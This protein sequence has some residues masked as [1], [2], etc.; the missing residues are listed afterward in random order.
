M[1]GNQVVIPE[2][3]TGAVANA[4]SLLLA[5]L[6]V[7]KQGFAV[8][9]RN[10]KL[11][12]CNPQFSVVRGYPAELC[13]PGVHIR[14]LF[15]FLAEQ[16]DFATKGMTTAELDAV[17]EDRVQQMSALT[18][19][20]IE[21]ELADGRH[22]IFRYDPIP[23][24]GMLATLVDITDMRQAEEQIQRMARLPEENPTPVMRFNNLAELE[25]SNPASQILRQALGC[26]PGEK[27]PEPLGQLIDRVVESGERIET[28]LDAGGLRYKVLLT[29]IDGA[30]VNLF[31]RDITEVVKARAQL[32]SLAKLPE[33]NPSPVLRFERDGTLLYH[34]SASQQFVD[35]L[36]LKVGEQLSS[37]WRKRFES[38]FKTGDKLEVEY[39]TGKRFYSLIVWP[40]LETNMVNVYGRDITTSKLVQQELIKSKEEA[41]QANQAKSSFL[42]NMSHE[43]RTPLNAIIGYSELLQEEAEDLPGITDLFAP[44]LLKISNAGKHLLGLINEVLDLSKIEA[45]RMDIFVEKFAIQDLITEIEH[46]ISPLIEKNNN[47]LIIQL[48]DEPGYMN[49]DITKIKQTLF[50]LLSNAGK[51]TSDGDITLSMQKLEMSN[52]EYIRFD[53]TD[54]GI[55]MTEEQLDKVFEPFSQADESTTR[56][57][58]G[59]GLGLTICRRFCQILGG[60]ISA[61]SEA[62]KGSVFSAE[63]IADME[64]KPQEALPSTTSVVTDQSATRVLIIDDDSQARELLCRHLSKDGYQIIQSASGS[65]ALA[66]ARE[67]M[68]DV[69][70]LDILMPEVDGWTVLSQLKADPELSNIPVVIVSMIEDRQRGFSLGAADYLTKPIA[71]NELLRVIKQHLDQPAGSIL[72]VDDDPLARDM[73]RLG[74]EKHNFTVTDAENGKAALT[75]LESAIPDLILLDLMMPEMDGFEFLNRLKSNPLWSSISVIVVTAKDLENG[76]YQRLKGGVSNIYQKSDQPLDR[77]LGEVTK[78]IQDL[79]H[80]N[81]KQ[82]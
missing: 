56:R 48:G 50:N 6:D 23:D 66:I 63:L 53:V 5:G 1:T 52:R 28:E 18:A 77:L 38:A 40:V 30:H 14:D 4:L 8:F 78:Q 51:F 67:Q 60:D 31:G 55:G 54:S 24:R 10:L 81:R 65:E 64:Q 33:Q 26:R 70:T 68:P 22:L 37:S 7:M 71:P 41:E 13:Q 46:T 39:E 73:A 74:L 25:Y 19:H 82:A 80:L 43:L 3:G 45:G 76:D 44:D 20:E 27:T 42:A 9:D 57:F 32:D 59:T 17:I 61:T 11:I 35:G 49:S 12:A 75:Q 36:G 47:K 72:V 58:G 69:I 34:N 29:S 21:K 16:D 62:G 15:R 79:T 2:V